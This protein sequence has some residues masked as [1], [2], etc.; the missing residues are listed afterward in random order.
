MRQSGGKRV[1]AWALEG[2]FD[3][4]AIRSNLC[5]I[6]W[7]PRSGRKLSIPEVD[8]AAWFTLAAAREKIN[9]AQAAFLDRLAQSVAGGGGS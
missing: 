7:P 8:R 9:Q 4:S 2:E 5:E 6:E 3:P 1:S